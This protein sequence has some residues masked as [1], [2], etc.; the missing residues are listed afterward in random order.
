MDVWLCLEPKPS[1]QPP[2]RTRYVG[3]EVS[4]W[5]VNSDLKGQKLYSF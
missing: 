5:G 4:Q 3:A 2:L 1:F